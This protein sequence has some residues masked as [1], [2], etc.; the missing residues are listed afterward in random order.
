MIWLYRY[1]KWLARN[2]TFCALE[3]I[4]MQD[5]SIVL[6]WVEY[7]K[8]WFN[9]TSLRQATDDEVHYVGT[10][11]SLKTLAHIKL[12]FWFIT[13][14]VQ[15]LSERIH[16]CQKSYCTTMHKMMQHTFLL[17]IMARA[18]TTIQTEKLWNSFGQTNFIIL[19]SS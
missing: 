18:V 9:H 5:F 7:F 19:T 3:F 16:I 10:F 12:C 15:H 8:L 1:L 11:V 6:P 17:H 2:E 13:W 4:Q 14:S